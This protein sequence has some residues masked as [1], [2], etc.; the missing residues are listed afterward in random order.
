MNID[1]NRAAFEAAYRKHFEAATGRPITAEHMVEMRIGDTY[2]DRPFLNGMWEAWKVWGG[3]GAT[4]EPSLR[5][6]LARCWK[7]ETK[8]HKDGRTKSIVATFR[9][10]TVAGGKFI[11]DAVAIIAEMRPPVEEQAA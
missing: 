4:A 3:P 9:D 10:S 5:H 2:G 6:L 8:F 11:D 1:T 7:F